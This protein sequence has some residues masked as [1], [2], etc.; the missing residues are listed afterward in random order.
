[1]SPIVN[2]GVPQAANLSLHLEQLS[3]DIAR[4]IPDP[5]WAG[6]GIFD[7]EEWVPSYT[8]NVASCGGHSSKYQNYSRQLVMRRHPSWSPAQVEAQAKTEFEAAAVEMFVASL[9]RAA[10]MRPRALWGFY[11]FPT[12]LSHVRGGYPALVP[13]Q[14]MTEQQ[15]LDTVKQVKRRPRPCSSSLALSTKTERLRLRDSS[16]QYGKRQAQFFHR[17][18]Q[19]AP[20][21]Q[22]TG[23]SSW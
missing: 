6:L 19:P 1:M 18:T 13:P 16:L 11:G 10:A 12:A 4:R 21:R 8:L 3:I 5:Q 2:G 15:A 20:L 23:L 22:T 9:R 14:V 7:F 17:C